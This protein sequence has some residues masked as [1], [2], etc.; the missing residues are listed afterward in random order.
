ML[1]LLVVVDEQH[2]FDQRFAKIL[3]LTIFLLAYL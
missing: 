2:V 3:S 1:K